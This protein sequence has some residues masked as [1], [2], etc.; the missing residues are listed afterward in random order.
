MNPSSTSTNTARYSGKLGT[1][2]LS[3]SSV[4]ST[5]SRWLWCMSPNIISTSSI[6]GKRQKNQSSSIISLMMHLISRLTA[7]FFCCHGSIWTLVVAQMSIETFHDTNMFCII[8]KG[9]FNDPRLRLS[10][11][12]YDECHNIAEEKVR[13]CSQYQSIEDIWTYECPVKRLNCSSKIGWFLYKHFEYIEFFVYGLDK[14]PKG[15]L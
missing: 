4:C 7:L 3:T 9:T 10:Y 8:E 1:Q 11:F 14:K 5:K 6:F 13:P 12:K 15:E 2:T